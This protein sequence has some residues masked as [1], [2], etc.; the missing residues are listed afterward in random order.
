MV[1][2][3]SELVKVLLYTSIAFITS[4]VSTVSLGVSVGSSATFVTGVS[5]SFFISSRNS[6]FSSSK[7]STLLS[8]D[9]I[10]LIQECALNYQTLALRHL[11]LLFEK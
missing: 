5:L 6:S 8:S 1:L 4:S 2:P 3:E 7:S 9:V 10:P 11:H